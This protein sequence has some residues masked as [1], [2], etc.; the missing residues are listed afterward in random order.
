MST[1][2]M[3]RR[4]E[5]AESEQE[6]L[7]SVQACMAWHVWLRRS[8]SPRATMRCDLCKTDERV[9]GDE[10]SPACSGKGLRQIC[11]YEIPTPTSAFL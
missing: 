5:T 1:G 4:S 9:L 2:E 6:F 3:S 11:R 7:L 8:P 10:K